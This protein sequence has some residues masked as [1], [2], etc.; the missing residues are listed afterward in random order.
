MVRN[1]SLGFLGECQ[2]VREDE[3]DLKEQSEQQEMEKERKMLY[4][5]CPV[6][7]V[8]LIG[9]GI[10]GKAVREIGNNTFRA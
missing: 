6:F 9:L 4:P 10:V 3:I 1:V 7:S 5:S 8:G 2:K